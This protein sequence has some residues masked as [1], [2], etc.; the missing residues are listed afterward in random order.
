MHSFTLPVD[1]CAG[2]PPLFGGP[3]AAAL[4]EPA[5]GQTHLLK[6]NIEDSDLVKKTLGNSLLMAFFGHAYNADA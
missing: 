1:F 2:C 5:R 6:T 4:L 3:I